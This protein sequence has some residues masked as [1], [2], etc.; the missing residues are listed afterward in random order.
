MNRKGMEK[1][2][3]GSAVQWEIAF[4]RESTARKGGSALSRYSSDMTGKRLFVGKMFRHG[5]EKTALCS[6][7]ADR[8]G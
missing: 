2:F 6:N 5:R 4:S 1:P 3:V 7:T 8:K